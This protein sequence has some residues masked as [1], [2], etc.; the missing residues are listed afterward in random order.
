MTILERFLK[1]KGIYDEFEIY[2]SR[3]GKETLKDILESHFPKL[4]IKHGNFKYGFWLLIN[5]LSSYTYK[6]STWNAFNDEYMKLFDNKNEINNQL[7]I[8]F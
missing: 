8:N 4:K 5:R 6:L 1:E 3:L 7:K 2:I